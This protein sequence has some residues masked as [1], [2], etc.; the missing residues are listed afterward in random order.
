MS[1]VARF[2]TSTILVAG[3]GVL[4]FH[5][6]PLMAQTTPAQE[7]QAS[8]LCDAAAA[9]PRILVGRFAVFGSR[10]PGLNQR[11]EVA[12]VG[13]LL[14]ILL[15]QRDAP[16]SVFVWGRNAAD[17][18]LYKNIAPL[19]EETFVSEA[20]ASPGDDR[21]Q[22]DQSKALAIE[23][24]KNNCD[25]LIGGR[26]A[27]EGNLAR[28]SPYVFS[29]AEPESK[30]A[31]QRIPATTVDVKTM[32]KV[33]EQIALDAL[34]SISRGA[35]S[36]I[37]A[38]G[39]LTATMAKD[40]DALA[41]LARRRLAQELSAL[42]FS[43]SPLMAPDVCD[44]ARLDSPPDAAAITSGELTITE[45]KIELRPLV[46]IIDRADD[47]NIKRDDDKKIKTMELL[48][49]SSA[50]LPSAAIGLPAIYAREVR[51][52]LLAASKGGVFP[53]I[54]RAVIPESSEALL[55]LWPA[56]P[57]EWD[58]E[59]AAVAAYSELT[60]RPSSRAGYYVL[61]NVL[62]RKEQ[63]E[64]ALEYFL[65]AV[66]GE[67]NL[68]PEINARLNE[69]I[70]ETYFGVK[71]YSEAA[72]FFATA[73]ELYEK[74]SKDADGRRAGRKLATARFLLGDLPGAIDAARDQRNLEGDKNPS[75]CWLN[76]KRSRKNSTRPI[77]GCKRR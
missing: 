27:K 44:S 35:P 66:K 42:N 68:P 75:F 69:L 46:R 62:L 19:I 30:A 36:R 65:R 45:E 14:R 3:F 58:A 57:E 55:S 59:Q 32:F 28:I 41:N 72:E 16:G 50:R 21:R 15:E 5:T 77:P 7:V 54:D 48:L 39:C 74:L 25:Y 13:T 1:E 33:P 43:I 9:Q 34:A 20:V 64:V 67:G 63:K 6:A 11:D 17:L 70:G 49:P 52:L 31:L 56:V 61:G 53:R 47:K 18:R 71:S 37:I 60:Q 40:R 24:K 73:K 22:N 12:F 23:L 38:I 29:S 10:E 76:F 4:M 26:I 8:H 2:V 51:T